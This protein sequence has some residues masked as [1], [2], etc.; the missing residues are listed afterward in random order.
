MLDVPDA[1]NDLRGAAHRRP[2]GML[3]H[4]PGVQPLGA[5]RLGL[6]S[7]RPHLRRSVHHPGRS[8][9]GRRRA[10]VGARRRRPAD[11]HAPRRADHGARSGLAVRPAVR[12]VLGAA[13]RVG[14]SAGPA[15]RRRRGQLQRLRPR[16]VLGI[17]LGWVH[18]V[19]QVLRHRTGHQGL[20][21]VDAARE[22]PGALHPNL[23][24][25]S[26]KGRAGSCP[27]CSARRRWPEE[28]AGWFPTTRRHVPG[29]IV[30]Q[31]FWEDDDRLGRRADGGGPGRVR[32]RL[33]T[34]REVRARSAYLPRSRSCRRTS[35]SCP[36]TPP[37]LLAPPPRSTLSFCSARSRRTCGPPT[38]ERSGGLVWPI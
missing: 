16:R 18:P 34:H 22:P 17:V 25:V 5:G 19:D 2:R 3:R 37:G 8:G 23:R 4:V 21:A 10:A 24:I 20:P 28:V 6:R 26:V 12:P 30:D 31:P 32:F 15:R 13:R 11:R 14:G 27:T 29:Q 1:R 33:A 35:G 36:T 7:P 38:T 9:L